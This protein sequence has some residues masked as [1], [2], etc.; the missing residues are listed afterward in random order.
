MAWRER[1][2]GPPL[3]HVSQALK[4]LKVA[5]YLHAILLLLVFVAA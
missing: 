5:A 3:S 4:E 1:P 2:H